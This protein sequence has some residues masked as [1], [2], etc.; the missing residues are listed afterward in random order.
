ME[1]KVTQNQARP[2]TEDNAV[3][4]PLFI[5]CDTGIDDALAL[6]YL[7]A[8][9]R[10]Q[11]VGIGTVSGNTFADRAALNTLALLELAGR[12]KIPVAV[13]AMGPLVGDFSGGAPQ[14]HGGDGVGGVKLEP[15]NTA[16][17]DLTA[18]ELLAELAAEWGGSLRVLAL[19]PLTNLAHLLHEH[20]ECEAM[21]AEVIVMGGAFTCHGNISDTAEANVFND[22]EAAAQV[23][24]A[25]WPLTI[26]PLDITM[27]HS[28]TAAQTTELGSIPGALPPVL[29]AMLAVYLE[30]YEGVF[31][32]RRCALHDPL[33]AMVA[34]R[35]VTL[36][37]VNRPASIQVALDG[38]ERGR[39]IAVS[40]PTAGVS[41]AHR[42]IR[43]IERPAA[44]VLLETLWAH[45]WPP[46]GGE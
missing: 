40:G 2:H 21:I 7:L 35:A 3:S 8:D 1:P 27:E 9:P 43:A 42:I 6:A 17:T 34:A 16:I 26:L 36:I 11:I 25:H 15:K 37:D 46:V 30:A 18:V 5:D 19:G 14:I 31:G 29:E 24:D 10:V 41:N 22:P 39:T 45:P 38:T 13:G 20:P 4:I 12:T 33:A 32:E 44:E 23:F 28:L